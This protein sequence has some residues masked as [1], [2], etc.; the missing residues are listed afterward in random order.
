LVIVADQIIV[1][2]HQ[3]NFFPWLGYFKKIQR[4]D[5]FVFLDAVEI[6][7]GSWINRVKMKV[8][9]K[10]RW[11]TC[12]IH[13]A[14]SDQLLCDVAI[15]DDQRWREKMVR[16]IKMNY[17]KA[18]FHQQLQPW[19]NALIDHPTGNLVEY[20]IANIRAICTQLGLDGQ[21]V[22]QSELDDDA[23]ASLRGS[24]RLARICQHL[25][26]N[27]YL[28]GDGAGEYEDVSAYRQA[29]IEFRTMGF[30]HPSYAQVGEGPFLPG[31]SVLDAFLNLGIAG[32]QELLSS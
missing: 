1:S 10:A 5:I 11:V 30:Q 21:F 32:V 22:R 3:P 24:E 2:I 20:N 31:L 15:A 12:P 25:D 14:G 16:T 29:G 4:A 13:T 19:L 26:A 7:K 23:I 8:A 9:G 28:A 27:C 17:S 18:P 6:S